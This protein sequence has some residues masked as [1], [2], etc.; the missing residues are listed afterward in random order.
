[1]DAHAE[2]RLERGEV[3]VKRLAPRALRTGQLV[4]PPQVVLA[5][6]ED[7]PIAI[8]DEMLTK[9]WPL[10]ELEYGPEAWPNDSRLHR[11]AACLVEYQGREFYDELQQA[12]DE[13]ADEDPDD[14]DFEDYIIRCTAWLDPSG[15]LWKYKKLRL[16]KEAFAFIER[17]HDRATKG[18]C[19]LADPDVG[20]GYEYAY[21]AD[22]E[23]DS[24]FHQPLSRERLV[25]VQARTLSVELELTPGGPDKCRPPA[26]GPGPYPHPRQAMST[27]AATLRPKLQHLP[28]AVLDD[29]LLVIAVLITS[30]DAYLAHGSL[31]RE[32]KKG[33]WRGARSDLYLA[34]LNSLDLGES[35]ET[36]RRIVEAHH[37]APIHINLRLPSGG[38]AET[39]RSASL[40]DKWCGFLV[41]K[42]VYRIAIDNA[43]A[44]DNSPDH[45]G[46]PPTS[47][48]RR[49]RAPT[50]RVGDNSAIAQARSVEKPT[51][52]SQPLSAASSLDGPGAVRGSKAE[53]LLIYVAGDDATRGI[54]R[55]ACLRRTAMIYQHAPAP[56]IF[57]DAAG[58]SGLEALVREAS[59]GTVI[60]FS[61]IAR[62]TAGD[63]IERMELALAEREVAFIEVPVWYLAVEDMQPWLPRSF[64]RAFM[65]EAAAATTPSERLTAPL[66]RDPTKGRKRS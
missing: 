5:D 65:S 63:R 25:H 38:P 50:S 6:L 8:A 30:L 43:V 16:S 35:L 54:Q 1:M 22:P 10:V 34:I 24:W 36:V 53:K 12:R 19:R 14:D 59:R 15:P 3:V 48:D 51:S 56:I 52:S 31:Q 60:M 27:L 4:L 11:L 13:Q 2:R 20:G 58:S 26:P 23:E 55:R 33:G 21:D 42:P 9:I 64:R 47:I 28:A 18:S 57:E 62:R 7:I 39:L 45:E 37:P 46:M 29:D 17:F 32:V 44:T 49:F 41:Y 66:V 40:L 61:S